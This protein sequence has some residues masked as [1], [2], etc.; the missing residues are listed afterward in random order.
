MLLKDISEKIDLK[1]SHILEEIFATRIF[2]KE[3]LT[4]LQ[5]SVRRK[6]ILK[7]QKSLTK[8]AKMI[9]EWLIKT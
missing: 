5:L 2:K 3:L 6:S 1:I 9:Q 7:R 8:T 4:L